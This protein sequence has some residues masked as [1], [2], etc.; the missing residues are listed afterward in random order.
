MLA[1]LL[2]FATL[3]LLRF[4]NGSAGLE[5]RRLAPLGIVIIGAVAAAVKYELDD[6]PRGGDEMSRR[7]KLW[8][9]GIVV[10]VAL[11]LGAFLA[12]W[13]DLISHEIGFA[14]Q[15]LGLAASLWLGLRETPT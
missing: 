11:L 4:V 8:M 1:G 7:E 10:A 5:W 14:L 2:M 15:T 3:N 6:R 12:S 13:S 9:W